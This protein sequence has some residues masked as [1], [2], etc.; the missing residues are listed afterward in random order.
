MAVHGPAH[1]HQSKPGSRAP[2]FWR[3]CFHRGAAQDSREGRRPARPLVATY[4]L[5]ED[6]SNRSV[7]AA[8]RSEWFHPLEE[9]L[10]P[11]RD[12]IVA[13]AQSRRFFYGVIDGIRPGVG[14]RLFRMELATH[15]YSFLPRLG[16]LLPDLTDR[17]IARIDAETLDN[18]ADRPDRLTFLTEDG[19]LGQFE[20]VGSDGGNVKS[21]LLI[22]APFPEGDFSLNRLNAVAEGDSFF[23]CVLKEGRLFL[24]DKNRHAWER[25]EETLGDP[26]TIRVVVHPGRQYLL[27]RWSEG[28]GSEATGLSPRTLWY[29][30]AARKRLIRWDLAALFHRGGE[31]IV[32]WDVALLT[33]GRGPPTVGGDPD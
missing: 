16:T 31:R 29:D 28:A 2:D 11:G 4:E 6:P 14:Q 18:Q 27:A 10:D 5:Q 15:N 22:A 19:W 30:L 9:P 12:R 13:V 21:R 8:N 1:C 26:V 25:L 32:S 20:F 23:A 33:G 17:R 7:T 24:Y 3:R